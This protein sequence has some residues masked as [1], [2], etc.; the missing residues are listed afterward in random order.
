MSVENTVSESNFKVFPST[1]LTLSFKWGP[2]IRAY[3]NGPYVPVIL[4]GLHPS[5]HGD[6]VGDPTRS[7]SHEEVRGFASRLSDL[8]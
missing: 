3:R 5:T 8:D 7:I 2:M 6:P 1:R 4:V